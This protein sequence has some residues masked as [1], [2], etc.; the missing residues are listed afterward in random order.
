MLLAGSIF[1]Q[2]YIQ[3]VDFVEIFSVTLDLFTAKFLRFSG[4]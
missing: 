4:C 3:Y 2:A 1:T